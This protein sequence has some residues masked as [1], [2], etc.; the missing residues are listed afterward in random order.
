VTPEQAAGAAREAVLELGGAFAE[1]PRTLRKARQLGLSGWAFF[2]AGRG[3]ALGD[4]RSD[5]VA[6]ALGFIAPEAVD[7]GW[8][9]ARRVLQPTE[10]AAIHL[11]ECCRWGVEHLGG[12]PVVDR[13]VELTQR[14]VLAADA[15]GMPL[16]A[17]W[18]AMP[19]PDDSPGAQ[20]AVLLHLMRE[21]RGGAHLLAVRAS[22]LTPLEAIISGPEGEAGAVAYGW[23]PPYPVA[24]PLLRKRLWAEAVTDRVVAPAYGTLDL[25][26]RLELIGL[27][28]SAR[29]V[30]RPAQSEPDAPG[31]GFAGPAGGAR[32]TLD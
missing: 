7:D 26:E 6:A 3:G 4:V 12:F 5:T 15:A 9:A 23:Q 16:F 27:L 21:H 25:D 10:V 13:L 31:P 30:L 18:R 24:G 17:A 20:A 8:D 22:G 19:V 32:A 2:I 1:D 11:A 29:A 14:I 28:D